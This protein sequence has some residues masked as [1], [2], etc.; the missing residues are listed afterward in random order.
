MSN[1][2]GYSH[3]GEPSKIA[4]PND[5]LISVLASIGQNNIYDT[6]ACIGQ[7]L[8]AIRLKENFNYNLIL[9]SRS[10]EN[11]NTRSSKVLVLEVHLLI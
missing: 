5:I 6:E 11:K 10:I 8:S 4:L 7:G 9:Y 2:C 1:Y 3:C